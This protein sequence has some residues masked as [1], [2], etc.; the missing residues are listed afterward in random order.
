MEHYPARDTFRSDILTR[1]LFL[2]LLVLAFGIIRAQKPNDAQLNKDYVQ[3]VTKADNYLLAGEYLKALNEYD[4]A[5][6]LSLK[7]KYPEKKIDQINRI[8]ANSPLSKTLFDKAILRGD[9]CFALKN[10]KAANIEFYNALRL[11]PEAQYPKDQLIRISGMF[12]DPENDTRYRIMLIHAGNETDRA[13]YD[14]AISYYQRAVLIKP[15]ETWIEKKIEDIRVLKENDASTLDPYTKRILEADILLEQKRW[16]EARSACQQALAL[17]PKGNYP[18]AKIMLID[19]LQNFTVSGEQNFDSLIVEADKFYRLQDFENAGIWYQ[20][21]LNQKPGV[22]YPKNM[23]KKLDHA[24]LQ[25]DKSPVSFDAAVANADILSLAGDNESALIGFERCNAAIPGD[26]YVLSRIR[27]LPRPPKADNKDNIAYLSAISRGDGDLAAK[28]YSKALSEYLYASW[29][30]PDESYPKLKAAEAQKLI[31][32][33]AKSQDKTSQ[34]VAAAVKPAVPV[35]TSPK[36]SAPVINTPPAEVKPQIASQN[37]KPS[38]AN[39]PAPHVANTKGENKNPAPVNAAIEKPVEKPVVKPVIAAKPA[40]KPQNAEQAKYDEAIAFAD[41][42]FADKNY[43]FALNGYKAALKIKPAEKYP[44]DQIA[45]ATALMQQGNAVADAYPKTIL[46]ADRAFNEKDYPKALALYQSARDQNPAQKYP[47]EKIAAINTI[48]GQQKAMQAAYDKAVASADIAFS[49]KS[50]NE[51]IQGYQAA[52]KIKPSESYP[53]EKISTINRLLGQTKEQQQNYSKLIAD[54]DRAFS[55]KDYQ[56]AIS[57]FQGASELKPAEAYPKQ[58][59]TAIKIISDQQKAR[60]DKYTNA[61]AAADMDYDNRDYVAALTG[62]KTALGIS[63]K[64]AYPKERVN[65]INNILMQ[66]KELQDTYD[67]AIAAADKAFAARDYSVAIAGYQSAGNLK[68]DESYPRTKV[69][70]INRI[71]ALDKDKRDKQY[72]DYITQAD[73]FNAK[74]DF[75][76]AQKAYQLASDLK[77]DETYPREQ[78]NS[79][80]QMLMNKAREI[81]EAYGKAI[82]DADSAYKLFIFDKAI[83]NYTRALEIRPGEVYPGQ[84]IARIRKYMIDNSVVEVVTENFILKN[85][86]EQRFPFKPVDMNLRKNN[87]MVLRART[88]GANNPKLFLSY[89]SDKTKNGGVV[90]KNINSGIFSDFIIK[91]SDQDKWFR[92]DNNWLSLYTENGDLEVASV[93]ISQGK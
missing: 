62:Y 22:P 73:G 43:P 92:E 53:K 56:K 35:S 48:L 76:L 18:A 38:S 75:L 39:T 78:Y 50:Y 8:L 67:K 14:K 24:G 11:K 4:K 86:L 19:H 36:P 1:S 54:A 87:Y 71:I 21:A 79:I 52:L 44:R 34:Q 68:P 2:L 57:L 26:S 64:E 74:Q 61:I 58:R 90:L 55:G 85:E 27:E 93:R 28:N 12:T 88:A 20:K 91:I 30:K 65:T 80:T 41:K 25:A 46:D 60:Q 45:Q 72:T 42:S 49:G 29:L 31:D 37:T 32:E 89:G 83:L 59:I 47:V 10:Y 9:S 23:L 51:A 81:R 33:A 15:S 70:E 77:P 13:K 66:F 82:A 69:A 40:G 7:Q 63:P 16:P 17:N 5:G 6:S 3:A 84:M